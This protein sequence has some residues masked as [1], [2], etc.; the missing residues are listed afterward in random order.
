[1]AQPFGTL[2][3]TSFNPMLPVACKR[4][5]WAEKSVNA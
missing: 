3:A 2:R 5:G 1:M 4:F